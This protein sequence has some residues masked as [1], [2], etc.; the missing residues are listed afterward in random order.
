VRR[1]ASV[2]RHVG[3]IRLLRMIRLLE[4]RPRTVA[5]LAQYFGMAPRTIWRDFTVIEAAGL[6]IEHTKGVTGVPGA[7]RIKRPR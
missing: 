4:A 1:R 3:L 5:A 7:Y 6:T 2:R